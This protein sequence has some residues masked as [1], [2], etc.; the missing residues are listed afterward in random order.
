MPPTPFRLRLHPGLVV[1]AVVLVLVIGSQAAV[2]ATRVITD[3]E[4][5]TSVQLKL[6]DI[7]EVHLR[8]NPTTGYSWYVH[9]KSTQ[10]LKLLGQSQ[11]QSR[12]PGVGRPI[13]QVFRF[14]AVANGDGAL[15]LHYIRT[16]ERQTSNE[17]QFEVQVSIR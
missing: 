9:P 11:A 16:W 8:S 7:L 15:L 2:A 3:A 14:Q 5:G 13:L 4:K 1:L 12:Q 10:L 17:E 6:G